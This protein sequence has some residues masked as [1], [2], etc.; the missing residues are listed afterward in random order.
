M[1]GQYVYQDK[2][3]K[4]IIKIPVRLLE[5][6]QKSEIDLPGMH[7]Y[8]VISLSEAHS[9]ITNKDRIVCDLCHIREIDISNIFEREFIQINKAHE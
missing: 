4:P 9:K 1:R 2:N 6:V 5:E 7:V 8:L 3:L